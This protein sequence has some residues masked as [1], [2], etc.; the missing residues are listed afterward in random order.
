VNSTITITAQA[1]IV[2]GGQAGHVRPHPAP[3][4]DL[5]DPAFEV[6]AEVV[7]LRSRAARGDVQADQDGGEHRADRSGQRR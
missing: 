5:G 3:L 4:G 7:P 1:S 6:A 2:V